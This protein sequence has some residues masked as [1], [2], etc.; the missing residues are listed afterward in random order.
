MLWLIHSLR[1]VFNVWYYQVISVII[2]VVLDWELDL[3]DIYTTQ[4]YS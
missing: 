4:D 1:I 3:L 2:D